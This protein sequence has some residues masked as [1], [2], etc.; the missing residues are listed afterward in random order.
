MSLTA[1]LLLNQPITLPAGKWRD[2]F[3]DGQRPQSPPHAS[4]TR[5]ITVAKVV[6]ALATA[7]QTIE[8]ATEATGLSQSTVQS[9]L[10]EL[11]GNGRVTTKTRGRKI[12]CF[13]QE[14][15]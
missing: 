11:R 12:F 8:S 1:T 15:A 13:L 9:V 2:H 4:E 7:P 3:M 6:A 14:A 10:I 5:V